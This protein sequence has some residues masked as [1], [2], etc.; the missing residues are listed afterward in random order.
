M[1]TSRYIDGEAM[2]AR[3][4]RTGW[5]RDG[6]VTREPEGPSL[7]A[8]SWTIT[9]MAIS[10]PGVAWREESSWS[11]PRRITSDTQTL[12]DGKAGSTAAKWTIVRREAQPAV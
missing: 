12:S 11:A 6:D 2:R 10:E 5:W 7:R 8:G 9:A 1:G 3:K 4:Q